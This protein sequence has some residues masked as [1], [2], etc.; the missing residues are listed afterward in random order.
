MFKE[1]SERYEESYNSDLYGLSDLTNL[2]YCHSH[3]IEMYDHFHCLSSSQYSTHPSPLHGILGKKFHPFP[4]F[5]FCSWKKYS[6]FSLIMLINSSS[7]R[8]LGEYLVLISL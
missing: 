5:P 4:P 6:S 1:W 3:N 2:F 8:Y 7:M